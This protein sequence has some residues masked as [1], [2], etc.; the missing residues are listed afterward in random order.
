M[1]TAEDLNRIVQ[2]IDDVLITA[3]LARRASRPRAAPGS[4]AYPR[5]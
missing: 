2:K 3:E 5:P 4:G 1:T